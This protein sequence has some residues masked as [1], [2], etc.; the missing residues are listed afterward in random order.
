VSADRVTA[1]GDEATDV[2]RKTM[3]VV[4]EITRARGTTAASLQAIGDQLQALAARAAL[5]PPAL[6]EVGPG[7][8]SRVHLLSVEPDGRHALYVVSDRSGTRSPPHEH[9]TWTVA[10]A[11]AGVERHDL[12]RR[13]P[14]RR[15]VR[16]GAQLL[17]AGGI[18][19]LRSDAIH[20]TEVVSTEPTL[21]LQLYGIALHH[22][23]PFAERLFV[24]V[25]PDAVGDADL[26]SDSRDD[27]HEGDLDANA[28]R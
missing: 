15:A 1:L 18:V 8:E 7:E 10:A 25:A 26:S 19:A 20:A 4:C 5:F 28:P 21:H 16:S 3:A 23:P 12:Y 22:L 13:L 2:I 6:L 14:E 11:I 27:D 17:A 9:Q 24:E